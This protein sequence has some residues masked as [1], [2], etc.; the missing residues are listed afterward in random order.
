MKAV[1]ISPAAMAA[2]TAILSCWIERRSLA[3]AE[4]YKKVLLEHIR[5]VARGA[6]P[7]PKSC[8]VLM[9]GRLNA[10]GLCHCATEHHFI[11]LREMETRFEV[12]EFIAQN[13]DLDRLVDQR[14]PMAASQEAG[15]RRSND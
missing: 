9:R 15:A 11:I 7:P 3:E 12:V 1:I 8:E 5:T 14:T 13:H 4:E 6:L 10:T 2:L